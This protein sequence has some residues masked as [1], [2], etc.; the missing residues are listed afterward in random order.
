MS[1]SGTPRA[2]AAQQHDEVTVSA[3][4]RI[5]QLERKIKTTQT[6]TIVMFLMLAGVAALTQIPLRKPTTVTLGEATGQHTLITA[7]GIYLKGADGTV[8]AALHQTKTGPRLALA[9]GVQLQATATGAAASFKSKSG[10]MVALSAEQGAIILADSGGGAAKASLEA[11]KT[12]ASSNIKSGTSAG[13]IRLLASAKVASITAGNPSL[14]AT[15]ALFTTDASSGLAL[16]RAE[17]PSKLSTDKTAAA[18]L[19]SV[20]ADGQPALEVRRSGGRNKV[21]APSAE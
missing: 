8:Q 14:P 1:S 18:A 17:S 4:Q 6:I 16:G 20:N 7:E 5:A 15:A 2:G 13:T 10:P 12:T 3:E 19:L 21:V 9:E 11:S